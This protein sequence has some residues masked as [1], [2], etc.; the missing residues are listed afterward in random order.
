VNPRSRARDPKL[1]RALLITAECDETTSFLSGWVTDIRDDLYAKRHELAVLAG[2]GACVAGVPEAAKWADYIIYLGHGADDALVLL[3]GNPKFQPSLDI[4]SL[5]SRPL[6]ATACRA[7]NKLGVSYGGP[8]VGY[9]QDF[10]FNVLNEAEFGEVIR[11][12]IRDFVA[13]QPT[14][15]L[16]STLGAHWSSLANDFTVGRL[17]TNRDSKQAGSDATHNARCVQH[18]P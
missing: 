4:N 3:H 18:K 9:D 16:A 5:A 15:T 11:L 7:W 10:R 13:G 2:V 8:F 17:R 12:S 6:Y 14:H 1:A